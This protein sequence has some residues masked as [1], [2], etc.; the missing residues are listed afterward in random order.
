[1]HFELLEL[2]PYKNQAPGH[3]AYNQACS[4]STDFRRKSYSSNSCAH[5]HPKLNIC[6][7]LVLEEQLITHMVGALEPTLCLLSKSYQANLMSRNKL[8]SAAFEDYSFICKQAMACAMCLVWYMPTI[9]L[10]TVKH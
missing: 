2:R 8:K 3:V 4:P 7:N 9:G 6:T 10:K 1:M 5:L